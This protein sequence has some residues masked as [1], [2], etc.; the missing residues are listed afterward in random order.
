MTQKISVAMATY[1][2]MPYVKEQIESIL[3]NLKENDE[4]IISDDGSKDGTIEEIKKY[5]DKDKRIKLYRGPHN[6]IKKNFENAII[7]SDGDYVFLA[8]QDDIWLCDK[9]KSVLDVFDKNKDAVIVVH[10]NYVI[11]NDKHVI[12]NSLFGYRKNKK[13]I[14]KN[15][16]KNTYIGCCMAFK[17]EIKEKILPIPENI[18]MHDQWIGIVGEL[19]GKS[20][21]TNKKLM[22]Y[23]RHENNNSSFEHYPIKIMIKNRIVFIYYFIKY[24]LKRYLREK[25]K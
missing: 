9:I 5:I 22:Y 14:L 23:R 17:K 3:L 18:L 4:L 8:D 25:I 7:H 15:I 10:D 12:Y 11:N 16:Y 24:I 21:F 6:T 20:I 13:G 2:G 19:Y 1:N